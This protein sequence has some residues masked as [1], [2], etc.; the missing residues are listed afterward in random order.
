MNKGVTL[1]ELLMSISCVGVVIVI[2]FPMA[3]SLVSDTKVSL[4][5]TSITNIEEAMLL[6]ELENST[7]PLGEK[8]ARNELSEEFINSIMNQ[9][10]ENTGLD[11][12]ELAIAVDELINNLYSIQAEKL[13]NYL[14]ELKSIDD[15][16]IVDQSST[17]IPGCV[18]NISD[19][20]VLHFSR[21]PCF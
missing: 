19:E 16:V 18:I 2:L 5:A 3:S 1:T 21:E 7:L 4:T 9:I 13:E 12:E 20:Q 14:S 11:E 6:Y 8:I 15:F 10:A 17:W